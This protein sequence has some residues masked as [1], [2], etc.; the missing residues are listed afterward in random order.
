LIIGSTR[1]WIRCKSVLQIKIMFLLIESLE[2]LLAFLHLLLGIIKEIHLE[3]PVFSLFLDLCGHLPV[4]KRRLFEP[5]EYGLVYGLK[6][7]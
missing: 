1:D 2:N 5:H 7:S 6:V 4:V 3:T